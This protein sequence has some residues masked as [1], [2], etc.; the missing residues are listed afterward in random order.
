MHNNEVTTL[1]N[2]VIVRGRPEMQEDARILRRC[3]GRYRRRYWRIEKFQIVPSPT[4]QPGHEIAPAETP[5]T[6]ESNNLK[7]N[8][9]LQSILKSLETN[10]DRKRLPRKPTSLPISSYAEMDAF[11]LI[12]DD[13]YGELIGYFNYIGGFN[14]KETVNLCFKEAITDDIT[15]LFTW[16]G[17]H[18]GARPLYN[19]RIILAIY[20]AVCGNRNFTKPTRSKFQAHKREALRAAKQRKRTKSRGPRAEGPDRRAQ[21]F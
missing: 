13:E 4:G 20:E 15:S 8:S 3:A 1:S 16:W 17:R 10:R 9:T 18:D 19:A 6:T 12:N 14:L 11:E 5:R 2:H 7:M 21:N